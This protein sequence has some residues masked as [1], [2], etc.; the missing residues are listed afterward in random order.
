LRA[1]HAEL[2]GVAGALLVEGLGPTASGEGGQRAPVIHLGLGA[3]HL[4]LVEDLGELA[5]L[6]LVELELVGQEAQRPAHAEATALALE[7][8]TAR[9]VAATPPPRAM[10]RLAHDRPTPR[11]LLPRTHVELSTTE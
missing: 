7:A 9:L 8:L 1:V 10:G 6:A 11:T 4:Q 2:A 5:H 3:L